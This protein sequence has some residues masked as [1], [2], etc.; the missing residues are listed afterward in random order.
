MPVD[1]LNS[2]TALLVEATPEET[3]DAVLAVLT[4]TPFDQAAARLGMPTADLADA[5]DT[6]RQAGRTALATQ[7]TTRD[8]YQV[9]TEFAD[10]DSAENTAAAALSPQ[11]QRLHDKG[12]IAGWWF[13]RKHPCWR[14]R[15]KPGPGVDLARVE[16][17]LGTVLT[18]L[19]SDGV[20]SRWRRTLYEPETPAFGGRTAMSVAH[21]LF[22]ADS[23]NILAY[24]R[25]P[26]PPIA[27]REL[28][29]LLCMTLFRA[30]GQEWL[31]C[32]D[33]WHRVTQ[34]RP[35]LPPHA[36]T[37]RLT[38]LAGHL[39]MLLGADIRPD[40]ALFG[41]T[42]PLTFAAPWAAAFHEAGQAL[43][44]AA[45]DGILEQGTRDIL[46]YHVIFHWNRFGLATTTQTLLAH[47]AKAAIFT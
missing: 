23:S 33:I 27:R 10:W 29:V 24:A 32:G 37:D 47:A 30:A 9:H 42:G 46:R 6:Y 17:A 44:Q 34:M 31:E 12:V 36:P 8:W 2:S 3:A 28:S 7:A 1:R 26:E 40:G 39:R 14:L 15:I 35:P 21:N 19:A 43:A 25:H 38:E 22:C 4:G 18:S 5:L 11:L 16:I 45:N 13:I 20:I 41:T